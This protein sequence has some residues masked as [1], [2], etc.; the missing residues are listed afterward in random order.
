M[1]VQRQNSILKIVREQRIG[2][3]DDLRGALSREG[4]EATQATV[5]RDI[6]ELGLAKLSDADGGYYA[7]PRSDGLRPDLGSVLPSLLVSIEG[8]GP[9]LVIKTVAGSAGAVAVAVDQARWKEVM[10]TLAG[11][12]TALIIARSQRDRE[13]VAD[14]LRALIR[15]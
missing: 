6:R 7:V 2:S 10:G 12:D 15:R 3:Q 5:S 9:M 4:F 11:D 8:V 14:R 13:A 1:K